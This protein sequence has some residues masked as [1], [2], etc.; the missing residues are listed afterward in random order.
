MRSNVPHLV[1]RITEQVFSVK[2]RCG[3]SGLALAHLWDEN[4]PQ[5]HA[6]FYEATSGI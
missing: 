1:L 6:A 2:S 5:Q 3:L 4:E